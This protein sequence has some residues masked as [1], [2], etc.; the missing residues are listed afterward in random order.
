MKMPS[1]ES[2]RRSRS[3][4]VGDVADVDAVDED[5]AGVL[6]L[7]EARAARVELE[8]V[9]VLGA[10]DRVAVDPDGLGQRGVQADPLVVAVERHHVAG[11][12]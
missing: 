5:H 3:A 7:A 6:G 8:H 12:A 10:E 11:L 4:D 9:A 1:A 2:M